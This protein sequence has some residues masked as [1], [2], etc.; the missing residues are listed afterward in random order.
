AMVLAGMDLLTT[1]SEAMGLEV[2]DLEAGLDTAAV[3]TTELRERGR[4]VRVLGAFQKFSDHLVGACNF[5]QAAHFPRGGDVGLFEGAAD[6]GHLAGAKLDRRLV[7]SQ[8]TFAGRLQALPVCKS[9]QAKLTQNG[10]LGA[11]GPIA[12]NAD[13]AVFRGNL[14]WAALAQ[15]RLACK[16]DDLS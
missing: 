8:Q 11:N 2:M 1:D 6:E 7:G 14:D 10:S 9:N 16:G 5:S 15:N 12:G 3:T 4:I 13:L